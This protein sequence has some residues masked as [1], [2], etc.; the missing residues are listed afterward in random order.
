MFQLAVEG[1]AAFVA[2]V[3][4]QRGHVVDLTEAGL[5]RLDGKTVSGTERQATLRDGETETE[6]SCSRPYR[7]RSG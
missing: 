6:G 1:E 7:S 2:V 4:E 3:G 5:A